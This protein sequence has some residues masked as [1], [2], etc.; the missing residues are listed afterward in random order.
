MISTW[1]SAAFWVD[2]TYDRD[3]SSDGRSRFGAYLRQKAG[4]FAD[5]G[6]GTDNVRFALAAWRIPLCQTEVRHPE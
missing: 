6:D 1:E 4:M 3:M 2:D 5:E